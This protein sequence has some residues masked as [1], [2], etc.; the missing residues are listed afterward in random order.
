MFYLDKAYYA[1]GW[2]SNVIFFSFLPIL[3][4]FI[5]FMYSYI[6]SSFLHVFLNLAECMKIVQT[7]FLLNAHLFLVSKMNCKLSVG[8][9]VVAKYFFCNFHVSIF[10]SKFAGGMSGGEKK[11]GIESTDWY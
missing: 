9:Y 5:A 3:L 2:K 1:K 11:K 7:V 10:S 4:F 6:S 8:Y